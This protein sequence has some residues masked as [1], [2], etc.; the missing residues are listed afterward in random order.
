MDKQKWWLSRWLLRS[1]SEVGNRDRID[2]INVLSDNAVSLRAAPL[3]SFLTPP[4][5]AHC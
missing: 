4:A 5:S 3:P 1:E 2:W